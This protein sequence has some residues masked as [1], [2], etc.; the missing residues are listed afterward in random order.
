MKIYLSDHF[1]FNRI[2]RFTSPSILMMIL[3][4]VYSIVDGFFVSNYVGK[5][6]FAAVNLIMPYLMILTTVGFMFGSGGSALVSAIRGSG[7]EEKA[8]RVFSLIIYTAIVLSI[9]ITF[10]GLI[11]LEPVSKLIGAEDQLLDDCITYGQIVLLCIPTYVIQQSFMNLYAAAEKPKLGLVMS[12]ISGCLNIL[13]DALFIIVF[14]W[15]LTG[16]ALATAVSVV[17]GGLFPIIYFSKPRL[18]KL[19]LVKTDLDFKALLKVCSNGASELMNN[20]SF[21]LVVILYNYQLM[22]YIGEN[23]IAAYGVVMYLGFICVSVFLGYTVGISPVISYHYG[24]QN[25]E[26]LKNLL[27][28]SLLLILTI[29]FVMFGFCEIFKE[30][31]SRI[32]VAYDEELLKLTVHAFEIVSFSYLF[33]GF[34]IFASGFFTALNNGMIS[35][36]ISFFRTLCF[37]TSCI[38]LL[39]LIFGVDGIWFSVVFAEILAVTLSAYFTVSRKNKYHYL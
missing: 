6:A 16:A 3:I 24:A 15:G 39:P 37:E 12:V 5:T 10:L 28:K 33:T 31:L 14:D 23:G 4:S 26:E 38:M 11:F 9:I 29:S 22:K 27:K 25:S 13:L 21:S 8:R 30:S 35:A 19:W 34:A 1:N 17:V 36:V 7:D 2:I 32:F 20:I 18:N